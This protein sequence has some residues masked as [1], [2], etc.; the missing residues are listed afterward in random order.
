MISQVNSTNM[1]TQAVLKGRRD[2]FRSA[3]LH[4]PSRLS[5]YSEDAARV[6]YSSGVQLVFCNGI[7][8]NNIDN[9][10]TDEAIESAIQFFEERRLPFIWWSSS[11][12]LEQNGFLPGGML[13]GIAVDL[14]ENPLQPLPPIPDFHFKIAQSD[15][16]LADFADVFTKSYELPAPL[17]EQ[18]MLSAVAAAKKG[19]QLHYIGYH[20]DKPVTV[21]TLCITAESAGLWNGGT[22]PEYRRKG[23]ATA[24][25]HKALEE[26]LK[27]NQRYVMALL[28][29]SGDAWGISQ[30]VGFKEVSEFPFYA[31]VLK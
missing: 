6:E 2:F 21:L 11:P 13:K 17:T 7:I 18:F 19:E 31:Y 1:L 29:P 3:S 23:F 14:H 22:L 10:L 8:E 5:A 24:L 16:E 4:C 30:S 15:N 26:V 28:L 27:R 20:K 25:G 12:K 9:E